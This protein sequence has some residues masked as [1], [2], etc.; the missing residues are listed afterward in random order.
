MQITAAL[1]RKKKCVWK[2]IHVILKICKN[3]HVY[4][5]EKGD[6]EH[7]NAQWGTDRKGAMRFFENVPNIRVRGD[8]LIL[9][10]EQD[11]KEIHFR[12]L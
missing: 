9:G 6:Q 1:G 3:L 8:I 2:E 4:S 7:S 12:I 5:L 10:K 11:F